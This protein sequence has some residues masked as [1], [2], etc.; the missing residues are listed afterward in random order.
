MNKK[1]APTWA[2][3]FILTFLILQVYLNRIIKTVKLRFILKIVF[4]KISYPSVLT[5]SLYYALILGTAV[6]HGLRQNGSLWFELN[7]TNFPLLIN[8]THNIPNK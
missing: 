1:I 6:T 4:E 8:L 5:H 3:T 7:G 2:L